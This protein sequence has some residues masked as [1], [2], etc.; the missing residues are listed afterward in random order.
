MPVGQTEAAAESGL[1]RK[2]RAAPSR[3]PTTN[4]NVQ[5]PYNLR[6]RPSLRETLDA[7]NKR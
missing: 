7:L 3:G 4:V 5:P 1:L 6:T 2:K